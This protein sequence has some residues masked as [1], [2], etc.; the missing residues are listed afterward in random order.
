MDITHVLHVS[1]AICQEDYPFSSKL[2]L[3]LFCQLIVLYVWI[4]FWDCLI[5][6]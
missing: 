5:D 2:A 3:H 4:S 6:P 1:S